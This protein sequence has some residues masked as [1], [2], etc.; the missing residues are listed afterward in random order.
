MSFEIVPNTSLKNFSIPTEFTASA[1]NAYGLERFVTINY[2]TR[3]SF[4][5]TDDPRTT[6]TTSPSNSSGSGF[7]Q[8]DHGFDVFTYA[9]TAKKL[10]TAGKNI[11]VNTPYTTTKIS[12]ASLSNL[13]PGGTQ[14]NIALTKCSGDFPTPISPESIACSPNGNNIIVVAAANIMVSTNAGSSWSSYALP[15][16]DNSLSPNVICDGSDFY[17]LWGWKVYKT[18]LALSGTWT[19][20]A[21]LPTGSRNL[22]VF[23]I[24]TRNTKLYICSFSYTDSS[25]KAGVVVSSDAITWTTV[26]FSSMVAVNL[27]TDFNFA[28][29]V[30]NKLV[31]TVNNNNFGGTNSRYVFYTSDLTGKTGWTYTTDALFNKTNFYDL[32]SVC[33]TNSGVYYVFDRLSGTYYS[34]DLIS[35][36]KATNGVNTYDR[37]VFLI[38]GREFAEAACGNAALDEAITYGATTSIYAND[39]YTVGDTYLQ[40]K[41]TKQNLTF[42]SVDDGYSNEA[43][44]IGFDWGYSGTTYNSFRLNTNGQLQFN[45]FDGGTTPLLATPRRDMI[46]AHFGDLLLEPGRINSTSTT[47]WPSISAPTDV[48]IS[49][50]SSTYK[51]QVLFSNSSLVFKLGSDASPQYSRYINIDGFTGTNGTYYTNPYSGVIDFEGLVSPSIYSSLSEVASI[52]ISYLNSY[53][54]YLKDQIPAYGLPGITSLFVNNTTQG[55]WTKNISWLDGGVQHNIFRMVVHCARYAFGD[56]D[57]G[58]RISLYKAG[59]SQKISISASSNWSVIEHSQN[60]KKCGPWPAVGLTPSKGAPLNYTETSWYSDDNGST[61]YLNN[62]KSS[63]VQM[64]APLGVTSNISANTLNPYLKSNRTIRYSATATW[65]NTFRSNKFGDAYPFEYNVRCGINMWNILKKYIEGGTAVDSNESTLFAIFNTSYSKTVGKDTFTYKFADIDQSGSVNS[66]DWSDLYQLAN[67]LNP[68]SSNSYDGE[69]R[70]AEVVLSQS[71]QFAQVASDR[72]WI[73]P[74]STSL[75]GFVSST[76]YIPPGVRN[77]SSSNVSLVTLSTLGPIHTSDILYIGK[78][79]YAI[80]QSTRY[81]YV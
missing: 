20:L 62:N 41:L 3:G 77:I 36:T 40:Q 74:K 8:T 53:Q 11:D 30:G 38:D 76:S 33:V 25:D 12:F 5:W 15:T 73:K 23:N 4:L 43:I 13:R 1:V 21:T 49:T 26:F 71:E 57:Y 14:A 42:T 2:T 17:I 54:R 18:N 28:S 55:V 46:V 9:S 64:G 6:W 52:R 44:N 67:G 78:P 50:L 79:G 65:P 68:S 39:V 10:Y 45:E 7:Q 27:V 75:G 81:Y 61:W 58:Y 72:G 70:L 47:A 35:W 22:K 56:T 80:P 37:K 59:S 19:L 69:K 48:A 16:Q 63:V 32:Q 60:T 29:R 34:N 66:G 31:A 51:M 24:D